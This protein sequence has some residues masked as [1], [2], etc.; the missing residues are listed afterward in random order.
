MP[1]DG[2]T[3]ATPGFPT[4]P[5]GRDEL[6]HLAYLLSLYPIMVAVAV[7]AYLVH[8]VCVWQRGV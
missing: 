1:L 7:A 5:G 2:L 8:T 6:P 3:F 4:A